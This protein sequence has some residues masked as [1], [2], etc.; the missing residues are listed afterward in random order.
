MLQSKIFKM[1]AL[2]ASCLVLL[3]C[4][5]KQQLV[6]STLGTLDQEA[7][8]YKR[9]TEVSQ[10]ED[11]SSAL[12]LHT[13]AKAITALNSAIE[14]VID[15]IRSEQQKKE[16]VGSELDLL[17]QRLE[18]ISTRTLNVSIL[19]PSWMYTDANKDV[20]TIYTQLQ[21]LQTNY[22]KLYTSTTHAADIY[23][24][25]TINEKIADTQP[26]CK[27]LMRTSTLADPY[28]EWCT[29]A[30]NQHCGH[31]MDLDC[32]ERLVLTHIAERFSGSMCVEIQQ[33]LVDD[34][35]GGRHLEDVITPKRW[36][37]EIADCARNTLITK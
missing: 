19:V 17:K 23:I 4:P 12:Q 2:F 7:S 5:T 18:S 9:F 34:G 13:W 25:V 6:D 21:R 28:S 22:A 15:K 33:R 16:D 32:V 30:A 10:N 24:K 31:K 29:R 20:Q 11:E 14:D 37:S 3:G 35:K 27:E 1:S 36:P 8:S 26:D